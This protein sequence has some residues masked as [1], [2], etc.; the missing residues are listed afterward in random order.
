[1]AGSGYL[2]GLIGQRSAVC[3]VED[4]AEL[5][6][7][8]AVAVLNVC[9]GMG[10]FPLRP[11]STG[12][13]GNVRFQRLL[14]PFGHGSAPGVVSPAV[15]A[16]VRRQRSERMPPRTFPP[17]EEGLYARLFAARQ[18]LSGHQYSRESG[19]R[20]ARRRGCGGGLSSAS[21]PLVTRAK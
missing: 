10:S 12:R 3:A 19:M 13:V 16:R 7:A 20:Q 1:M 8:D 6:W 15:S 4:V 21:P 5:A 9:C 18:H 17:C 2:T 14:V 11:W